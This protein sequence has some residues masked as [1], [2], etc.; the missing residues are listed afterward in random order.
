[1]G[2]ITPALTYADGQ[3][4]DTENHNKNVYD[5]DSRAG[6]MSEANG[7]LG[8]ANLDTSTF[9]AHAEHVFPETVAFSRQD[10]MSDVVQCFGDV[11]GTEVSDEDS[12]IARPELLRPVPG[13]ATRVYLPYAA[14]VVFWQWS[15]FINPQRFIVDDASTAATRDPRDGIAMTAVKIDGTL[16]ESTIRSIPVSLKLRDRSSSSN[17]ELSTTL[18]NAVSDAKPVRSVVGHNSAWRDMHYMQQNVAA[19]W[20]DIQLCAYLE[21]LPESDTLDSTYWD[22]KLMNYSTNPTNIERLALT[23]LG[24]VI[25]V[26][27]GSVT[28]GA[29][30]GIVT[31]AATFGIRNARVLVLY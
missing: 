26:N 12:V 3:T 2:K 27:R 24:P 31:N 7:G 22:R 6:I 9:V 13:C 23:Q 1:M 29:Y 28:V 8:N 5:D 21:H 15:Y 20:H 16:I 10:A 11:F 30:Y 18:S 4:L 14:S 19:G 25:G 17:P